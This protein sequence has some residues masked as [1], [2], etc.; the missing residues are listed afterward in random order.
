MS[1]P[2]P[3]GRENAPW[4]RSL[5]IIKPASANIP[6]IEMATQFT[7]CEVGNIKIGDNS[8]QQ[9]N[10][11]SVDLNFTKMF[12]IETIVGDINEIEKPNTVFISEDFAKKYFRGI[13]PIGQ[14]H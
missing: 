9:P 10:I 14:K 1:L 12:D 4:A 5:G 3:G 2:F 7:H 13:S 6:E 11:M 8:I